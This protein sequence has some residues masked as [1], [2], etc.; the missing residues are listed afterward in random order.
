MESISRLSRISALLALWFIAPTDFL[1]RADATEDAVSA[2][3]AKYNEIESARLTAREV[4]F[5]SQ[6][7]PV[8]GTCTKYYL[9]QELVKVKLSYVMGDHGGS[10]EYFYYSNVSV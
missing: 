8:S 2:I 6:D 9:G 1:C 4:N 3:R 7:D 5:E 10:D